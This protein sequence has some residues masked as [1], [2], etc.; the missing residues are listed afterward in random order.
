V[1][2]CKDGFELAKLV[3]FKL[4]DSLITDGDVDI[5]GSEVGVADGIVDGAMGVNFDPPH[6]QHAS[7]AL[8][9]KL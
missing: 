9:P 8:F 5:E 6:K 4:G 2:G 1:E 7:P 3:G